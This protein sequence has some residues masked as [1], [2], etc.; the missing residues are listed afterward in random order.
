MGGR[1]GMEILRKGY[2]FFDDNSIDKNVA[3]RAVI[4]GPPIIID[5]AEVKIIQGVGAMLQAFKELS[6]EKKQQPLLLQLGAFEHYTDFP[7]GKL[8]IDKNKVKYEKDFKALTAALPHFT[9]L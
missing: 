7:Q 9:D 2:L 4:D 5:R 3:A 1:E 8:F 6:L